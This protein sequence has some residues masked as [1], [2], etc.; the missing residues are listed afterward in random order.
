[1]FDDGSVQILFHPGGSSVI[2]ID[3]DTL[4]LILI[5]VLPLTLILMFLLGRDASGAAEHNNQLGLRLGR[6]RGAGRA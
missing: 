3:V 2:L 5:L 4:T 6:E 1:M